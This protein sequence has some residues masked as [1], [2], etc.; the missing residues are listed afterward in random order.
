MATLVVGDV[1]VDTYGSIYDEER[2]VPSGITMD[3]PSSRPPSWKTKKLLMCAGIIGM[4]AAVASSA[5]LFYSILDFSKQASTEPSFL[6]HASV[7][8]DSDCVAGSGAW[9]YNNVDDDHSHFGDDNE[10]DDDDNEDRKAT[11]SAFVTCFVSTTGDHC[12]SHSYNDWAGNWQACNPQG[13]GA[14][15]KLGKPVNDH[16]DATCGL[17]CTEFAS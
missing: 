10:H 13:Y 11:K 4:T 17:P 16:T 3:P 1:D 2:V 12:W 8:S 6:L 9:P 5:L 7:G 14:S 15:W